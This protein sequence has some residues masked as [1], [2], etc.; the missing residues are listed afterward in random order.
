MSNFF[1]TLGRKTA[2]SLRKGKWIYSNYFGSEEEALSWEYAVGKE[3][4]KNSLKELTLT[5]DQ[6]KIDLVADITKKLTA[7][8]LN[9]KRKFTFYIIESNDMNAF[10]L[11]GGFIFITTGLIELCENNKDEISF[12]LAHEMVHIVRGHPLKRIMAEKTIAYAGKL[13]KAG[14]ITSQFAKKIFIKFISSG[15]SQESELEADLL[16]ML[17]TNSAGFNPAAAISMLNKL[18][19]AHTQFN[20]FSTHPDIKDRVR[21]IHKKIYE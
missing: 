12:V 7:K 20:Y 17:L 3:L 9:K 15:Y 21:F 14:N 16:G 6:S 2:R 19:N 5:N 4:A 13:I 18:E 8:A 10:A 11:P 1:Y